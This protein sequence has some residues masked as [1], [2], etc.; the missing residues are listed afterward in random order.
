MLRAGQC[1][2]RPVTHSIVAAVLVLLLSSCGGE[3]SPS[4]SPADTPAAAPSTPAA[5]VAPSPATTPAAAVD[6][7]ALEL[8]S[9]LA[10]IWGHLEA[11][12][13]SIE[14]G[15]WAYAEAHAGHPVA[16]YWEQVEGPLDEQGL[17]Q[18]LREALDRYLQAVESQASDYQQALQ[19]AVSR[20]HETMEA[21]AG[22]DWNNP[23]F[24]A[25]L[26]RHLLESVEHEYSEAVQDGQLAELVE[27]QDAWGFFTVARQL[28]PD[29]AQQVQTGSHEAAEEI[30]HELAELDRIFGSFI[31]QPGQAPASPEEVDEAVGEVRA[32]LAKALQLATA[33]PKGP[34]ETVAEIKEMMRQ[35]LDAYARGEQDEAYDLAADAYLEGFE[36]IEGD[37]IQRGER[38]FV[39]E[40]EIQFKEF[41]DGIREG[42]SQ[43]ELQA[44]VDEISG[45]LDQALEVLQ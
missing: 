43:E 22:D 7:E 29:I 40:V 33:E 5:S 12:A 26:I 11:S 44:L 4:G 10:Q 3:P 28:Y 24:R 14:A 16:E 2:F 17:A 31:V 23:A 8:V 9:A 36:T 34:A 32:E 38:E 19:A 15:D 39:E 6:E 35:A 20:T 25:E 21:V 18:P 27:Y 30:E 41:R 45:K 1:L 37:L 13:A 42:R